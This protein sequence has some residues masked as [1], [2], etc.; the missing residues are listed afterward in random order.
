MKNGKVSLDYK[1][2]LLHI[3]KYYIFYTTI[4]TLNVHLNVHLTMCTF[5]YV[6]LHTYNTYFLINKEYVRI[7]G[8]MGSVCV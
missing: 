1:I 2:M 7:C 4:F 6:H 3:K 5:K 8:G